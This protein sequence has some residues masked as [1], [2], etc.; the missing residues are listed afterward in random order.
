MCLGH[1]S[2]CDAALPSGS[3]AGA[4]AQLGKAPWGGEDVLEVPESQPFLLK[5][6]GA[7]L[8]KL[9]DPDW[10]IFTEGEENFC[11]GVP[12]GFD[13]SLIHI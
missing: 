5:A 4:E 2:P 13:L 10:G 9:G 6:I 7:S 12:I 3:R 8:R 1:R 11:T